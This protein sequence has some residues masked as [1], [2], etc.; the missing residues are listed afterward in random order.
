MVFG[1][2]C[3]LVSI[4][5]TC[6]L[7]SFC[8]VVA[9]FTFEVSAERWAAMVSNRKRGSSGSRDRIARRK[10]WR[11]PS[12]LTGERSVASIVP[13]PM[14]GRV[15]DADDATLTS[16][17]GCREVQ[18]GNFG[19]DQ[20][21]HGVEGDSTGRE[22]GLEEDWNMKVEEE[23]DNEKKL[24]EQRRRLQ[25]QIRETENFTDMIRC[26]G[27][28][29]KRSGRKSYRRLKRRDTNSCRNTKGCRKGLKR[30]RVLR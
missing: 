26:S 27:T 8:L 6:V 4:S 25:K 9:A 18:T 17:Q 12:R 3:V 29:R 10:F 1:L 14:C 19:K 24:D 15:G 11:T 22:T 7:L 28:G 23:V 30:C 13:E 20:E 16:Q 21:G 5:A 2:C